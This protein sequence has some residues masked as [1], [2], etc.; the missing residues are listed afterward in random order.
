MLLEPS[1][2]LG[3]LKAGLQSSGISCQVAHLNLLLLKHFRH[4]S[5]EAIAANYAYNEFLFSNVL[6]E[7]A[8]TPDQLDALENML[9][10]T[11][12]IVD[13]RA[14]AQ[15]DTADYVKFALKCRN[16]IIPQ[17][18]ADCM[19]VVDRSD[20][21]MVGFT[22][23][24]DQT[25]A[26]IALAKLVKEKYPKMLV[27]L[28]GYAVKPPIGPMLL[29]SFPFLDAVSYGEGED[30]IAPLA[31]ASVDRGRLSGVPGLWYQTAAGEQRETASAAP[32]NL[33]RSP[34]PDYDDW[35]S[36]LA[37]M[38]AEHQVTIETSELPVESS[39]GCW[40]GQV[41]HCVFCGIDDETMRYRYKSPQRT[42]DV[43][44]ALR[45]KH[46]FNSFRF[47]D[48]ILPR[49][50]YKTLLPSL[51]KVDPKY[52]LQ[53]EMK[54][55]VHDEDVQVMQ[56]AGIDRVQP[57]I[58]SFSTPIL[59]RMAK[60]VTGIQNVLTLRL[61]MEYEIRIFYNILFGFPGDEPDE[62]RALCRQV[63][64]LYHLPPPTSYVP[65]MTTRYAPLHSDPARFG[66]T[67]SLEADP[68]YRMIFSEAL[69][70]KTGFDLDEYCYFFVTPY[71]FSRELQQQFDLLV[72]QL[73]HWTKEHQ[74]RIPALA[75]RNTAEGI[76]FTD[77]RYYMEAT[78][79][80]FGPEHATV[81]DRLVR[82]I[83][84]QERLPEILGFSREKTAELLGELEEARLLY[85][86][87]KMVTALALSAEC[88]ERW[89]EKAAARSATLAAER[90]AVQETQTG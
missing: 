54:A 38:E 83:E 45:N 39:R 69:R 13:M 50:Y 57:G 18:L 52:V 74:A 71:S 51:A 86:E 82:K 3:I 22:C 85:R 84:H 81:H 10:A 48:Y 40:W 55:N 11:G 47:S 8:A 34:V 53:W 1:L 90:Q 72:Y 59:K 60:G 88:C 44:A 41:S 19:Q 20:A 17:F 89:A 68:R 70:K 15:V 61:L 26:S 5:Y 63:P 6:Q 31:W 29:R 21:T 27:V 87:E 67:S 65:V 43:L 42:L 30:V 73:H 35:F 7:E 64:L 25:I 24:F 28:G 14:R 33:D 46:G 76:V 77:T 58:E 36:D 62:Y 49:P 80:N 66:I 9:R 16:E 4:N 23:M 12:G 2:G 37:M 32:V 79:H 75:Y 78:I 56:Q